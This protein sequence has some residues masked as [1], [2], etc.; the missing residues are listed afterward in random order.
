MP[1]LFVAPRGILTSSAFGL[2]LG[3]PSGFPILFLHKEKTHV[4]SLSCSIPLENYSNNKRPLINRSLLLLC[5]PKGNRTPITTL[6]AW[7]PN[8]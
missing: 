2:L 3:K 6:K 4:F 7:C 5:S 8:H 1:V